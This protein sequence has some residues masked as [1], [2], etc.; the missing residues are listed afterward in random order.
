MG[1]GD[2]HAVFDIHAEDFGACVGGD[3]LFF[4][5]AVAAGGL[6]LQEAADSLDVDVAG[7]SFGPGLDHVFQ[8]GI[9][10]VMF[11]F[12]EVEVHVIWMWVRPAVDGL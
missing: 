3:V 2:S 11:L 9:A 4:E 7:V 5:E 10:D 6:A 8:A 12:M 1:G